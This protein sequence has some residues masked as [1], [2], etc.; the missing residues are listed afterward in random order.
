MPHGGSNSPGVESAFL[1]KLRLQSLKFITPKT[2][3]PGT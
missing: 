1:E 3:T 2:G